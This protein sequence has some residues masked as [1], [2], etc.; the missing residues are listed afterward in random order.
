MRQ[1]ETITTTHKLKDVSFQTGEDD[2]ELKTQVSKSK[3]RKQLLQHLTRTV[4]LARWL[5]RKLSQVIFLY[6]V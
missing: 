4:T 6:T 1:T 2:E 3:M 5:N